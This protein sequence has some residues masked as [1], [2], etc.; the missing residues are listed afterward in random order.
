MGASATPHA[1]GLPLCLMMQVL[2][3]TACC[4]VLC[5]V[6]VNVHAVVLTCAMSCCKGP[7]PAPAVLHS[8]HSTS[9]SGSVLRHP[10]EAAHFQLVGGLWFPV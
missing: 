6:H 5:V 10:G 8:M 4:L 2:S 9:D 7:A 3:R 1:P